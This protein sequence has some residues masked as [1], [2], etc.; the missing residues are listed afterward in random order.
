MYTHKLRKVNIWRKYTQHYLCYKEGVTYHAS[1]IVVGSVYWYTSD[2]T[3]NNTTYHFKPK[4]HLPLKTLYM[5]NKC[6]EAGIDSVKH[7]YVPKHSPSG[8][9]IGVV[10]MLHYTINPDVGLT[11]KALVGASQHINNTRWFI[12]TWTHENSST[13]STY[14]NN[15][16]TDLTWPRQ[17]DDPW[18]GTTWTI[19]MRSIIVW[20]LC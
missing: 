1:P 13:N 14:N 17:W 2:C 4:M 18:F 11:R 9:V 20:G 8:I 6:H 5:I 16:M 19:H 10:P 3:C 7:H 15:D 12:I